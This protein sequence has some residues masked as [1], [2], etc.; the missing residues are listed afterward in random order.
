MYCAT[1]LI[2][3][4]LNLFTFPNDCFQKGTNWN[5]ACELISTTTEFTSQIMV[6]CE[7]GLCRNFKYKSSVSFLLRN[8]ILVIYI[9]SGMLQYWNPSASL[10][11]AIS[12]SCSLP[13]TLTFYLF[14]FVITCHPK[15]NNDEKKESANGSRI[16]AWMQPANTKGHKQRLVYMTLS[17]ASFVIKYL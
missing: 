16:S 3:A 10:V 12:L 2:L 4:T 6:S 8:F 9:A 13:E 5:F 11:H 7:E 15:K 1:H 14:I 17:C